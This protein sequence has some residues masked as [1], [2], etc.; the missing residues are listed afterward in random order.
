MM[1][2]TVKISVSKEAVRFS[3]AGDLG[4]GSIVCKH[5]S[6]DGDDGEE[7][8]DEAVEIKLEHE[9][10]MT[11]ALRY[12]TAFSKSTPVPPPP[13][14][15]HIHIIRTHYHFRVWTAVLI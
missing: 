13:S 5:M 3:V 15:L 7:K 6:A 2:D 4:T 8:D 9:I 11:F 10:A 1:G 12:L 14:H